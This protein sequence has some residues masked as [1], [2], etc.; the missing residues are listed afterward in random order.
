ME[1]ILFYIIDDYSYICLQ[2]KI[3]N[4]IKNN[5]IQYMN[6]GCIIDNTGKEKFYT[7]MYKTI[8]ET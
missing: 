1:T 3:K 8:K 7:G 5:D 2:D 6:I 4:N